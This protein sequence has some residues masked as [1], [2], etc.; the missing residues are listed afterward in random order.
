[1][2]SS[3]NVY[4]ADNGN[5]TVRKISSAGLVTTV[6][7]QAGIAGLETGPL[8]GKLNAPRGLALQG[9]KTLYLTS[10]GAVLKIELP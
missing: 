3:G 6:A 9:D 1:V 4:V 5:H 2:D 10:A 7:G 8:P